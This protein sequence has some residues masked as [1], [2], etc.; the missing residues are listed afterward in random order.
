MQLQHS[1]SAK[2]WFADPI[3]STSFHNVWDED[4]VLK[5]VSAAGVTQ[6]HFTQSPGTWGGLVAQYH[7]PDS[8]LASYYLFDPPGNT[9]IAVAASGHNTQET[10]VYSAFGE[11]Y[12]VPSPAI[13]ALM[14]GGQ[15]GY[16]TDNN[17][18]NFNQLYV[19]ARYYDPIKPRW[20]SRDPLGFPGDEWNPY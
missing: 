7:V 3:G 10:V 20:L 19:R 16:Y 17:N 12:D 11:S 15:Q 14:F 1:Q 2:Y 6:Y 18:S 9:R 4:V 8:A 5:Q 13:V